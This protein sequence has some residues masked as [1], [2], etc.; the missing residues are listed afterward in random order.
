MT[1]ATTSEVATSTRR[2]CDRGGGA[3]GESTGGDVSAGSGGAAAVLIYP[4]VVVG[5]KTRAALQRAP[6]PLALTV[7]GGIWLA[8]AAGVV[9]EIVQFDHCY[10][11]RGVGS[12]DRA[13]AVAVLAALLTAA[14]LAAVLLIGWALCRAGW[15]LWRCRRRGSDQSARRGIRGVHR[16]DPGAGGGAG[17]DPG[18][19]LP[20]AA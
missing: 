11:M 15:E 3:G 14:G 19:N 1:A 20:H 7:K 17:S 12:A 18:I 9:G 5:R 13:A 16:G 4:L 10:P 2:R 8:V 6:R